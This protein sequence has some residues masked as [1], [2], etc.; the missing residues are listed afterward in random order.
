MSSNRTVGGPHIARPTRTRID[1]PQQLANL[2]RVARLASGLT[3]AQLAN[4]IRER[5]GA[6]LSGGTISARETGARDIPVPG[7]IEQLAAMGYHL[8]VEPDV[9]LPTS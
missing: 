5:G 7:A 6:S 3:A 1:N 8:V 9:I 4:R 2:L